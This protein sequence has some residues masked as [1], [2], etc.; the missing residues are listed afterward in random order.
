MVEFCRTNIIKSQN[1]VHLY[2]IIIIY[3]SLFKII[4]YLYMHIRMY[5]YNNVYGLV[6]V[7]AYVCGC[8]SACRYVYKYD[9]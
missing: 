9:N 6:R 2:C 5:V 1:V 4:P 3:I 8:T 7:G